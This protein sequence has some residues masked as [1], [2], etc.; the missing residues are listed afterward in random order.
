[1]LIS[2]D[3]LKK[4]VDLEGINPKEIADKI[5][6]HSF[7]VDDVINK[8][9]AFLNIVV[10][11]IEKVE[12]HPTAD[13]LRVCEV[14]ISKT[15]SLF[16][17]K[18][19][20]VKI[21]CGGSNLEKG[22]FVV[23]A[24]PGS[25]VK[26]HGEGEL[27]EIKETEL[28]GV[29]SFG[30]I[31]ASDEIGLSSIFPSKSEKEIIDLNLFKNKLKEDIKIG[32]NIA[33]LLDLN[34]VSFD[35]DNVAI[36]HRPDLWGHYGVAR[37]LSVIYKRELKSLELDDL[38]NT[39]FTQLKVEIMNNS[40]CK[41]YNAVKINNIKV[42]DSPEWLAKAMTS[43]GHNSINNI[44]DLTNYVMIELGQPLH[45]FDA[46]KISNKIFVRDGIVGEKIKT[47]DGKEVELDESILV[48]SDSIRPIGIA[49]VMG[50][51]ES[52][53]S[54]NTNS[55]VI[56]SAN[57]D[58][59]SIRKTMQKI[60]VRTDAGAR[61]EKQIDPEFANIA[62]A[63]FVYLLKKICPKVVIE[64]VQKHSSHD[65]FTKSI[66]ISFDF[67]KSRMGV[68]VPNF[69]IISILKKLGFDVK[70]SD[71]DHIVVTVPYF[72]NKD[73][74]IKE[75]LIEEVA[76]IYGYNNI[77]PCS[78][79]PS[80]NSNKDNGLRKF[81]RRIKDVMID[82]GFSEVLNYAFISGEDQKEFNFKDEEI[83]KLLNSLSV[84]QDRMRPNLAI[85]LLKN[86]KSNLKNVDS[87][88]IFEIERI[89]RKDIES[90]KFQNLPFQNY[91]FSA[92]LTENNN[93]I[94]FYNLKNYLEKILSLFKLDFEYGVSDEIIPAYCHP[95]RFAKIF[96]NGSEVGYISEINPILTLKDKIKQ[97][98]SFFEV[99][100]EKLYEL[101]EEKINYKSIPKF[102]GSD[103][104][105]SMITDENVL[106]QDIRK[107]V[108]NVSNFITTV[109]LFDTYKGEN[110][111]KNKI[112]LAF[113]IS[114]IDR[115]KTMTNDI[116]ENVYNNVV[117]VLK[118]K[119]NAEIRK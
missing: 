84:G 119:F 50:G 45:A 52:S 15:G 73:V 88:K 27:V 90:D 2:L 112:S 76:R 87:L 42:E 54:N 100:F 62:L 48:I 81:E 77:K 101:Q 10:G 116:I 75:D 33:D 98:I 78:L 69:E 21:V 7:E 13:K 6:E 24:L 11:K 18:Q 59:N 117:E 85:N 115:E 23:V 31:C 56:E 25:F 49:G 47:L 107:E 17:K 26:W 53:I 14:S 34:D 111:S 93:E 89:F 4:F 82:N 8:A 74:N 19:E 29:S 60:G 70:E 3:V 95:S 5:T 46:S 20:I 83:V 92:F 38:S 96:V 103:M 118:S 44:V 40:L 94:P 113:R 108:L 97:R 41:N 51:T 105:I 30:M 35:V 39:I 63:R 114:L 61:Y 109:D 86:I 99:D 66:S 65:A 57:F 67:I 68:D 9:S 58:G 79:L 71:D 37:E 102:Q 80:F 72:R 16:S 106:W 12:S 91:H 32:E 55:I 104:D 43:T 64:S 1:M 110:I 36:T 28:R 22:M